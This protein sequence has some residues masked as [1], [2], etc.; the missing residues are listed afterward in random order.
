MKNAHICKS[1]KRCKLKNQ[2]TIVAVQWL[3]LCVSQSIGLRIV[4]ITIHRSCIILLFYWIW[5]AVARKVGR[6]T[7]THHTAHHTHTPTFTLSFAT[8]LV[9]SPWVSMSVFVSVYI[10]VL[11]TPRRTWWW[12]RFVCVAMGDLRAPE[13]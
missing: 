13:G 3:T 7:C 10:C 9:H 6:T 1:T 5:L 8:T 2:R 12:K 11:S 4:M